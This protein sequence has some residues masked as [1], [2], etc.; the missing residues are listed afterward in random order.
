MIK[1]SLV[2]PALGL[3]D[4]E[5]KEPQETERDI[6][7]RQMV[8]ALRKRDE[9]TDTQDYSEVLALLKQLDRRLD[10]EG[11]TEVHLS[12]YSIVKLIERAEELK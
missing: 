8:S 9:F 7:F 12:R 4:T 1:E 6:V 11:F 10:E 2:S 3:A 5:K